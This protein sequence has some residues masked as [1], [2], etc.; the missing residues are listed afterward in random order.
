VREQAE[1]ELEQA[2]VEA[3]RRLSDASER[4]SRTVRESSEKAAEIE[5]RADRR[6]HEAESA[7]KSLRDTV[8]AQ[9]GKAQREAEQARR[10]A[11]A[12]AVR[13]VSDA[14]SEADQLRRSARTMLDDARGEVAALTTRRDAIA[15]ELGRL[16][17]VISALSVPDPP[18]AGSDEPG[19]ASGGENG[20]AGASS[21]ATQGEPAADLTESK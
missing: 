6:Q 20:P 2:R 17:G 4:A 5:A 12:E 21:Q 13:L 10:E 15:E 16:S 3:Q 9:V 18:L 14:R 19:S 11:R 1:R 7:A 8:T